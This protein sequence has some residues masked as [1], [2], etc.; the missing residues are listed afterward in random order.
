VTNHI[1]I[2][3]LKD[4]A[5][6]HQCEELQR[7]VWGMEDLSVVPLHLLL[8]AQ[9]NGGLVLGA[10]DEQ[11]TMVAFVFGFL[12]MTDQ[13]Q[14]KHCS[15]MA[16]VLPEYQ[17]QQI[18]YRLKLA[19]RE[20]VLAQ[21]LDLATWTYDPLEGSNA[22]LNIGKLGVICRI[23]LPD[24]YGDTGIQLHLGL[25]TDRFEVEWWVRSQRVEERLES[26]HGKLTLDEALDMG[27]ERANWT[28]FDGRG[29]LRSEV[30]DRALGAEAVLIEIPAD[31]QA[32]KSVDMGLAR[33]WRLQTR[34]I[35]LECFGAGYVATDFISEVQE[36]QRRNFY[37]LQQAIWART[38][39][40]SEE[41]IAEDIAK[42]KRGS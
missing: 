11:G 40:F 28:E 12:G 3:T 19:Q 34:E 20:H 24:V 33:E 35:F 14:V 30:A 36:G 31:F 21:D 32:I 8:T 26:R 15:H 2:R 42:A 37:L 39:G 38:D 5:Q 7:R 4:A 6:F 25:P 16:G 13:G 9:K 1:S 41:E 18:G 22:S 27:A 17:G 29:L 10:F 23:Y